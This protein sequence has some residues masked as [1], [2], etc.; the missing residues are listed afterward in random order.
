MSMDPNTLNYL[1]HLNHM[2]Q[3]LEDR[4]YYAENRIGELEEEVDHL[5]NDK[6]MNVGRIEYKFDQL[7]IE[8]LDGT[9][10]IGLTPKNGDGSLDDIMV[11]DTP[12]MTGPPQNRNATNNNEQSPL[13]RDAYD[14]VEA[15][16]HNE[17]LDY[18]I[19]L[20]KKQ[21]F[22]LNEPYRLFILDDVKK[23]IPDRL[24]ALEK[25]LKSDPQ[26]RGLIQAD[27]DQAETLLYEAMKKEIE[28]GIEQFLGKLKSGSDAPWF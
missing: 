16:L 11:G 28:M 27:P 14:R 4:L 19:Q 2:I 26:K 1:H 20:E 23:Q 12:I 9:L 24:Q 6:K 15:F 5:K 21:A 18:L 25:Q 3:T 10:N 22:P 7:K 17:A 13:V 8:K